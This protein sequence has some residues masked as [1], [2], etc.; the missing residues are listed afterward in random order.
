MSLSDPSL[1]MSSDVAAQ[2]VGVETGQGKPPDLP[3]TN[4]LFQQSWW[5]E[6]VASGL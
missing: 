3:Y 1:K 4:S 2:G 5:L 6:A